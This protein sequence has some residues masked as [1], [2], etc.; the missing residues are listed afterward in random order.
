ML[1][2]EAGREFFTICL[3]PCIC[4]LDHKDLSP[5]KKVTGSW[6]SFLSL[7]KERD[8]W[9]EKT[10]WYCYGI[11]Y[12]WNSNSLK[13]DAIFLIEPTSWILFRYSPPTKLH[14]MKVSCRFWD[15][16]V[17]PLP[18]LPPYL[19]WFWG[20]CW[21]VLPVC[22]VTCSFLHKHLSAFFWNVMLGRYFL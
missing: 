15:L 11:L 6:L 5:I 21:L 4:L 13:S 22:V 18:H 2:L 8:V 20:V 14:C 9:R 17:Y 1:P 16:Q 19:I 10:I 7:L 3:P 12:S